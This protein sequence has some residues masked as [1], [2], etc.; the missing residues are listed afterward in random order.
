MVYWEFVLNFVVLT[1]AYDATRA[2]IA[3]LERN[4]TR[5]GIQQALSSPEFSTT[6]AS[7]T[8][9]FLPSGDRNAPVQLVQIASKNPSRSG[10][11]FDFVPVSKLNN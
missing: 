4:P 1:L 5:I 6:G 7:G 2:F 9:R 10:T 3:A 8:I 11:G